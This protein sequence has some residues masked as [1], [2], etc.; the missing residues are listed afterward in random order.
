[1]SHLQGRSP[2]GRSFAWISVATMALAC[3]PLWAATVVQE[4]YLPLPETQIRN[5]FTALQSTGIGTT[6]DSTFSIVVTAPGTLVYVDQWEDGYEADLANPAQATTQVWGDGNTA[7][8]S[9]PGYA[10]DPA[11]LSAGTVLTLRNLVALPRNASTILFDG[12]DRIASTKAIVVA[13]AAW[14]TTPGPVL[15][16]AVE[17]PATMDYGTRYVVPVGQDVSASGM[18]QYAGLFVMA[19]SDGTSVSLDPDGAGPSNAVTVVL[20]RGES[21]QASGGI[22]KGATVTATK[23]VQVDL[24][25]GKIGGNFESRWY[26]L[27]P[28]E[29]WFSSYI[30]PV[31]TSSNG[32]PAYVYLFNTSTAPLTVTYQTQLGSGALTVPGTNGLYPFQVPANSGARFTSAGG[33][34]FYALSTVGANPAANQVYDWGFTLVPADDLTTVAVVGW[35]PG[36]SD[37]TRNGSPV[38]VTP[39]AATR[40]YVDYNGDGLGAYTDP[41]GRRYDAAYGLA[42]LQ[43]ARVYDPD[44]DQTAMRLY[45]LDGTPISA[46]WG[47]DPAVA[48]SGS[49]F[50]DMGTT[51]LPFPTPVITKT[52]TIQTDNAPAGL[53]TN[54]ILQYVITVNNRGLLA[55]GDVVVMDNLPT[56][57]LFYITNSTVFY[58]D[59]GASGGPVPDHAQ[60]PAFPLGAP[61]GYTIPVIP[62]GGSSRFTFLA[63]VIG[64]GSI[65]NAGFAADISASNTV[66]VPLSG[67]GSPSNTVQFVDASGSPA[68]AVV[69][70]QPVYVRVTD[71]GANTSPSS[72]QTV[73]ALIQDPAS[74]DL[75]TVTLLET[76]T[77]TGIFA[78]TAALPSSTA[79]GVAQQDGILRLSAGDGLLVTYSNPNTGNGSSGAATVLAPG[80]TKVLYLSDPGQS[81][82]RL[83]PVAAGDTVTTQTVALGSTGPGL[84]G[85]AATTSAATNATVLTFAHTPGTGANRLLL[86]AVNL[87]SRTA[88]DS[89]DSRTVSSVTYGGTPLTQQGTVFL[90]P[91]RTSIYSLPN[92]GAG[93]SNIVVTA[94]TASSISAGATTFN[95]V[96]QAAALGTFGSTSGST[97]TSGSL[98]VASTNGALVFSCA[99]W[100]VGSVSQAVTGASG[101]SALWAIPG[102]TTT[103]YIGVG[104]GTKPGAASVTNTYTASDNQQWVIAAVPILP[105]A[106]GGLGSSVTFTQSP[107]FALSFAMPSGGVVR[108]TNYVEVVSG[109]MPA[110]PAITA[111]L[112]FGGAAFLTLS[113]PVYSAGAGTLAWSGSLPAAVIVP[114][115]QSLWLQVDSRESAASFRI[116]YDSDSRPSRIL[117]P[118]TNVISV[119][120]FAA[121]SQPYPSTN[122]VTSAF[123][124]DRLHVRVTAA[125]PFGAYDI[126]GVTLDVAG[127]APGSSFS[128]A[129]GNAQVVASNAFSRTYEYAWQ[130]VADPGAF[131]LTATAI[132]GTEGVTASAVTR[133]NLTTLD[134]GTPGTTE[135]TTGANGAST[136]AYATN[137]TVFVRVTD[138][139]RNA[140]TAAVESVTVIVTN[141]VSGDAEM[142]Q[143]YET[144]PNTGIF[145]NALPASASGGAG[146]NSG[147]LHA[148]AGSVLNV[149][150]VDAT[151]PADTSSAAATIPSAPGVAALAVQKTLV[152]PASG[153]ARVGDTV[154]F[155]IR[156]IN[157][158][159]TTAATVS[160][161]DHFP[162]ASLAF[163]SATPAPSSTIGGTSTWS[164]VGPL[165]PG[166]QAV[167][168]IAF[169]AVAP[170]A[171]AT[172]TA[173]ADAGG[174][175][176]ATN[177]A[178]VTIMQPGVSVVK[179]I[180]SPVPGPAAVGDNVHYRIV[181]RN[182]GSTP[183]STLPLEDTFSG[184]YLQY[185]SATI[186]PD[187]SGSGSILWTNLAAA[188]SLAPGGAIT[189]DVILRAVGGGNPAIN[190]AAVNEA[191][192]LYGNSI[193]AASSSTGIVTTAATISGSVYN[194]KDTNGVY[195]AGDTP[196]QDVTLTLYTDPNGDGN[197]SDGAVQG[198]VGTLANGAYEF[199]NLRTGRYVIVESDL[200]GYA[201]S[202]DAA[203]PNDNRI[204]LDAAGLA[205]YTN[206]DFF[207]YVPAATNYAAISGTVWLDANGNGAADDGA[208]AVVGGVIVELVQDPNTNGV[209]D[210]G[211]PVV[212]TVQTGTNGVYRFGG[213]LAGS[214][215]IRETDL[216]GYWS[217]GDT[218]G[219]ND[220]RIPVTVGAGGAAAGNNF[221]DLQ[222]VELG[223]FA[224]VDENGNGRQDS[225]EPGLGGVTVQVYNASNAVLA[226]VTSTVAGAYRFADLMPGVYTVAFTP[227]AGY[228]FTT[229]DAGPDDTDSD[230]LPGTNC[231]AA[232]TLTSGQ[233]VTTADAGFYQVAAIAG[234]VW[235]DVNGNGVAEA[236][237]TNGIA[238]ATITLLDA[239][240]N[241]VATTVTTASGAFSFTNLP[242]GSYTVVQTPP[243]V[244]LPTTPVSVG[245]TVASGATG[246]AAFL[247]L[248]VFSI[249]NHVFEDVDNDGNRDFGEDGI[250]GVRMALFAADGSGHPAGGALMTTN[251]DANGD[252]RFDG[253]VAG[254]YSVVVDRERSAPLAGLTSSTGA[255]TDTALGGEMKDHGLDA[256]VSAGTVT[257]GI[258]SVAVAVGLGLQ[259]TNEVV[260]N[261][262]GAG[263][264]GP[265]GDAGDNLVIDFGFTPVYSLGNRVFADANNNGV[266]DGADAGLGNVAVALFSADG[267]GSPAGSALATAGTDSNGF[268][269]FDGLVAGAYVAVVDVLRSPG[270]AGYAGSSGAT[271][272]T[273]LAGDL[274][275]HGFDTPVTAGAVTNGVAGPAVTLGAGLQPT[276]EATALG[277]GANSPDGDSRDNLAMDFGF[278][279]AFSLGDRV[280]ADNGTGGGTV[281]NG[282]QDGTEPGL[283][284]VVLAL[285]AADLSGQP[286][287]AMLAETTTDTNGYYRFDGLASNRYVVVVD[288]DAS[289]VLAGLAGSAGNSTDLAPTGDMKDHG[290][291]TPLAGG[292]VL[293]GGIASV[294]V[295]LGADILVLDFGFAPTFSL[296]NRVFADDG[297]GGGTAG[298]GIRNGTEPGLANVAVQVKT[299]GVIVAVATT[300][301]NGYYRFDHL[302]AGVYTIVLPASDFGVSGVLAGLLS[303]TGTRAGDTG[304]KG[305]DD[306]TPWA[307]GIGTASLTL[308]PGLQP[309][310]ETDLESGAG[311][312]GL[313]GDAFDDLTIDFGLVA[314]NAYPCSFGSLVWHDADNN[315]VYDV[316]ESGL[317]GVT[318]EVWSSDATGAL[319]GASAVAT[320]V[321]AADGTYS[322]GNLAPGLYRVRIPAG[323]FAAG[324]PLYATNASSTLRLGEDGHI[325]NNNNGLQAAAGQEVL[326]PVFALNRGG[327]PVDGSGVPNEFG[328]GAALDNGGVDANGNMTVDFGFYS[329]TSGQ[330]I[331][332]SLGARVW[333]DADNDGYA[334]TNETGIGGVTL[335]LYRVDGV[336]NLT[337]WSATTSAADGTYVFHDLPSGT[338]WMVHIAATNFSGSGAL[339]AYPRS[340]GTPANA[341]NQVAHDNNGIQSGGLGADVWSPLIALATGTEPTNT[342]S[343]PA[344]E[345]GVGSGQDDSGAYVDANGDMTIDFGFTPTFSLGNR[346]FADTDNN[347]LLDGGE[348]GLAGVA[349]TLFAA[350]PSG[351]PT[352][353]VLAA[354]ST[355]SAGFYRFDDL[356]KG[357]YVVVVDR[358][359]SGGLAG[360]TSSSG[361]STNTALAGDGADHGLDAPVSVGA[362]TNGIA[363]VAVTLGEGL[364]PTA[365]TV[366]SGAGA[367]GPNGD[368]SDNLAMDFG[369]TPTYS[370]GNR[371]Y[372]DP[373][374]D[375]QPDMDDQ[376]E[377][378][379]P[380]VHVAVFAAD[381]AGEPAGLVLAAA[382][383]DAEGFYRFDGLPAGTYVIVVDKTNSPALD[384]YVG[385]TGL[386]SNMS[387]SGD[388]YDHG[389]DV[390]LGAGSVLPGGIASAP[391][392]VGPGL[393]PIGESTAP[394]LGENG[395]TG[396]DQDVLVVDFGF[397][398]LYS[399]GNR[400]FADLDNNGI[401][402][403][404][405]AGIP[406]VSLILFAA[407]GSGHPGGEALAATTSDASGYYRFDGLAAGVYVVLADR[408]GSAGLVGSVSSTGASA[409]T[410]A[411]G[412]LR[413]HGLDTLVSA[414][415]VTNG[416]ASSP[417]VMGAALEAPFNEATGAGA[418]ANGPNGD[419]SDNLVLDFGFYWPASI[420]GAVLEDVNGN[421]VIDSA[422]TN[423]LAGVTVRLLDAESN[424]LAI[425]TTAADGVYGFAGLVPGRYTI[426]ETDGAGWFSTGDASGPNDNRIPVTLISADASTGN[427]FL[428]AWPASVAGA[429]RVDAN[430]NGVADLEETLGIGGVTVTLQTTNG[431]T[432][433]ATVTDAGGSYLFSSVAPGAYVIV[434]SDPAGWLSSA[435]PGGANDNRIAL[436]LA[437]GQAS[438]GNVF[439]DMQQASLSGSVLED[440]DG[441]GVFDPDRSIGIGGVTVELQTTN[442]ATVATT[443]TD[444]DGMYLF[445]AVAPGDYVVVETDRAGWQSTAD[446]SGPNDNRIPYT[447]SSGQS[448]GGLF[449]LDTQPVEIRGMVWKEG[450][451]LVDGL[452]TN[453]AAFA[454]VA[455]RLLDAT[456]HVVAVTATSE[457]GA[458]AFTNVTTG[459]A[460]TVQFVVP[461][462]NNVYLYFAPTAA[463]VHPDG[464]DRATIGN[465]ALYQ[466][467]NSNEVFGVA[468]IGATQLVYGSVFYVDAGLGTNDPVHTLSTTIGLRLY[469]AAGKLLL[470][471][472][473]VDEVTA[474]E[475]IFVWVVV[476]GRR[477]LIAEVMSRGGSQFYL[478]E[479]DE[480]L[481][482]GPGPYTVVISDES[483]AIHSLDRV[484]VGDFT[485]ELSTMGKEGMTL[486]WASLPGRV[487]DV[488]RC[489]RLGGDWRP[490]VVNVVA[491]GERCSAIV[492]SPSEKQGFFKI[493][494]RVP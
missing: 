35:G 2:I 375:G 162:A 358:A 55:L 421:G 143:L 471:L 146:A 247:D 151:D 113:N 84:I 302:P 57:S 9:P 44:R 273:E 295:T 406:G 416:I 39:T 303:S 225:G 94:S 443:V 368:A 172:N 197:P 107:P 181:V 280:F 69:A 61:L 291:D 450:G 158:G 68:V 24:A 376:D 259:P 278:T 356:V 215:V 256:P 329:P 449:F 64:A 209:A 240:S 277:A 87:G 478:V 393:Q 283:S 404:A 79:S 327:E 92:P 160:V 89:T 73:T 51:I 282:V 444:A 48:G 251:T 23:P 198:I 19:G 359:S 140:N 386:S 431:A 244:C 254:S 484:P 33:I 229:P 96:N 211:E 392:A 46:V 317:A 338:N 315:G 86:V 286:A 455:V 377:D 124:G 243:Q 418:G 203:A 334:G 371:I 17:V 361:A 120:G 335:D 66:V 379:I 367:H 241:G 95:G 472:R 451:G 223:D 275:D 264:H 354:A 224:W 7:N 352:G 5:A 326:S 415:P 363:G 142:F 45:T 343:G 312:A 161:T 396:D 457:S 118:T 417:V 184:A 110:N 97:G 183:I 178:T 11:S 424:V 269:R 75:Q 29:Q 76:G 319:Q 389:R 410:S 135:F 156:V 419:D 62:R 245:V 222:P 477:I 115:N 91:L 47:E 322:A 385:V 136:N 337:F 279:P 428:D 442:G 230:P 468:S 56:N 65:V 72:A 267:S 462:T 130:T 266:Q 493:V 461:K 168:S 488:Y 25:T 63:R 491:G 268:Y 433:A 3:A 388:V 476:D 164:N 313:N 132:E 99:N 129:L 202:G 413:D 205:A 399:L 288:A 439:L 383:T 219:P 318:V 310:G 50:L 432:V 294:A 13:R 248:P 453:E 200:P 341:D 150:Y 452:W 336:S 290:I 235:L 242:P 370:I 436:T 355:D 441:L 177:R 192:D 465:D 228:L 480:A 77:N 448:S 333:N 463:Y 208:G 435:D 88:S 117:L 206:Q 349:V 41:Q 414:G 372:R 271:T 246:T 220:N 344:G 31:G 213:V 237:D 331:L 26:R 366:D 83:D 309:T 345:F 398:P 179:T 479:V 401:L 427:T 174:G 342:P 121:F 324:Q 422:D 287:G 446:A 157:S 32:N 126:A 328:P 54:D 369:F 207:D 214:Y 467:A 182:T 346:V 470:E 263:N 170:A 103:R 185:V 260:A 445:T 112:G 232:Y 10:S 454:E 258:A 492:P 469:R 105:A 128:V 114:T 425:A 485:A 125:D 274:T 262:P 190:S 314:A 145:T 101:Q 332:G 134:L 490:V 362:V 270:L 21:Y 265:S 14:A 27:Y 447:L 42:A 325:D 53:S 173:V 102:N 221:L 196:I 108:V 1:M 458:Y 217:T 320:A 391:V 104:A 171:P 323:N 405:D 272:N 22:L 85:V 402:D 475:P 116:L 52:S 81:L 36:S 122:A 304:D 350:N 98:A 15:A 80:Q 378:G 285:F 133:V 43:S 139:N 330:A 6:I 204:P 420:A 347:G 159:S 281:N 464:V 487:Y 297:S 175:I 434:E 384:L 90:S 20:N 429:V 394:G 149:Y 38:W 67:G 16:A 456:G 440:V 255:S 236:V 40:V 408:A 137:Q 353:T 186:A 311:A 167:I 400:V 257:N 293:P 34:P 109:S 216:P 390:P 106:G 301:G 380:G 169:T 276:G 201:S 194:D 138:L 374:N 30:T 407:D 166:Q 437:S 249:G 231:T 239:A 78:S 373:D 218:A 339:R 305:V 412:D 18:F 360:L 351:N 37:G 8:G 210:V 307:N 296:G 364:Q 212:Q 466:A 74:G 253:V 426:D 459:V 252:Y 411:A 357:A 289:G 409:D 195:S 430:G 127:P 187:G 123:N 365:E 180:I 193:P 153:A 340:G 299:N 481:L 93:P 486:A 292:T 119:A 191:V 483:G 387:A 152:A 163:L 306:A 226:T 308:G 284:N 189:N 250:A 395:S 155:S 12:R 82:D 321:T 348:E 489:D 165:A 147:L 381:E 176:A 71:L 474:G 298:D 144:G 49:P 233:A 111:A 148:P 482:P 227:P 300:D 234:H 382:A 238:D 154:Q 473:T 494:M 131:A 199:L 141:L 397:M 261:P 28:T 70:G 59:G 316:G 60:A 460:Y 58:A 188:G 438:E 423:G 4:F 100:D 403:G